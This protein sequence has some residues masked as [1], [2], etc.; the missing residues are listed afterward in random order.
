MSKKK[1]TLVLELDFEGD[2]Y[3]LSELEQ[4]AEGWIDGGLD[5][6]SDLRGWRTTASKVVEIPEERDLEREQLEKDSAK[7][8]ALEAAGV[9]NWEWYGEVMA[10]HH[11]ASGGE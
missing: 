8:A 9:D 10:E 6:H 1:L 3:S 4:L 2:Y 11:E 5:D 7:L